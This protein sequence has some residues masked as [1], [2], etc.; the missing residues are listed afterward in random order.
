[1][2]GTAIFP[3][4]VILATIGHGKRLSTLKTSPFVKLANINSDG[5]E[6]PVERRPPQL[7]NISGRA[8]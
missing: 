2:N 5:A 3:W 1:M 4:M 7:M 8:R 6:K